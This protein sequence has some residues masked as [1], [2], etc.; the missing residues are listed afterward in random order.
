MPAV[1][2]VPSLAQTAVRSV[3]D[4]V[5]ERFLEVAQGRTQSWSR[6][7][8]ATLA[9]HANPALYAELFQHML[10]RLDAI[11]AEQPDLRPRVRAL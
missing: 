5:L 2:P 3:L 7:L 1:C 9:Q 8:Y 11:F 10:I 4:L 6:G